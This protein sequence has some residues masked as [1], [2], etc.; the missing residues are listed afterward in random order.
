MYAIRSY[1]AASASGWSAAA[2]SS[3]VAPAAGSVTFYA[4]A[5]DAAG[6][7]SA[8][9]SATVTITLNTA[10]PPTLTVSTL[11]DGSYT[12]QETVRNNFV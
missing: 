4:W 5:K 1:Y 9:K 3:V 12:N 10:T 11:A 7:V 2:P 6:N 8:A